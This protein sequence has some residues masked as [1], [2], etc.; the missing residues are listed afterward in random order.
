MYAFSIQKYAYE[1]LPEPY[2]G[3]HWKIIER[4][5]PDMCILVKSARVLDNNVCIAILRDD[6]HCVASDA[7]AITQ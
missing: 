2:L 6:G 5:K 1:K 4:F 7:K 3:Y